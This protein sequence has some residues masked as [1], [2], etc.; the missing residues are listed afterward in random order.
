MLHRSVNIDK[1]K[2]NPYTLVFEIQGMS[3]KD[4]KGPGAFVSLRSFM[5]DMEWA[6]LFK[7]APVIREVKLA[8]PSV[9]II[10]LEDGT[11]NFSDLMKGGGHEGNK[12]KPLAFSISN[13]QVKDG[14]V[15]MD[16]RP[17]HKVH[18]A[19]GINIAVRLSRTCLICG[20]LCRALFQ[21]NINGTP[22]GSRAGQNLF[23]SP[24]KPPSPGTSRT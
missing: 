9:R 24:W 18:T 14:M 12:G 16:D 11:Y 3:V 2:F 4:N 17:V 1:I 6:S 5:V 22:S 20:C 23:Q 15:V 19:R 10:R 13:I 8:N 21:A 7:V